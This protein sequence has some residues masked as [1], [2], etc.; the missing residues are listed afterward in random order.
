LLYKNISKYITGDVL[1]VLV[2]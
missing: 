2:S 1:I